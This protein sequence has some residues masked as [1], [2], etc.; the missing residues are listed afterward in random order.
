MINKSMGAGGD[1]AGWVDL[2]TYLTVPRG[3]NITVTQISDL[4]VSAG[5]GFTLQLGGFTLR[6]TSNVPNLG[7]P[8]AGWKTTLNGDARL[9][10]FVFLGGTLGT[11]FLDG[12]TIHKVNTIA[13]TNIVTFFGGTAPVFV[14][15]QNCIIYADVLT[16]KGL[17]G[18]TTATPIVYL[19]GY[20]NKL[21]N[22]GISWS[23]EGTRIEN[24]TTDGGVL[25]ALAANVGARVGSCR[26]V[27]A[28]SF[29]GSTGAT[30]ANNGSVDGS[31]PGSSPVT[32][33]SLAAAF[34]S[35]LASS[36]ELWVLRN[37]SVL[38]GSGGCAHVGG[39]YRRCR[40][41]S[42]AA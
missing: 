28:G 8:L 2:A 36:P 13:A 31:A 39:Q 23:Q 14:K 15:V 32:G 6:I 9:L 5:Q 10:Q 20:N 11:V 17:E 16:T 40:R 24:I 29:T 22:C 3:D 38:D 18:A 34:L 4:T 7:S 42:S 25:V 12:L 41:Q 26:S 33:V 19:D 21:K 37:G 27:M 35:S 1:F 30:Y